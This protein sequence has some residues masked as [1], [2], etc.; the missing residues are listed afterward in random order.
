MQIGTDGRAAAADVASEWRGSA[1]GAAEAP[2]TPPPSSP[3]VASPP[4]SPVH[5]VMAR[6]GFLPR[7]D[8]RV[9]IPH[10]NRPDRQVLGR[11]E[12]HVRFN[13]TPIFGWAGI[14]PRQ[15]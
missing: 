7:V 8:R 13:R 14:K 15:G 4:N 12:L 9:F 10:W 3:Q 1:A 2:S 6:S 11:C 5:G